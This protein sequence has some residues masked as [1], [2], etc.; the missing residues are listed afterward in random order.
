MLP[1]HPADL[2]LFFDLGKVLVAFDHQVMVENLAR[3][4]GVAGESVRA[5]LFD[6][7]LEDAYERGEITSETFAARL[8]AIGRHPVDQDEL[9]DAAGAMFSVQRDMVPVLQ[10]CRQAGVGMG[11]L[12]NTCEA[13]WEWL[14]RHPMETVVGWFD[15]VVLSYRVHAMKP[16][17]SI[18]RSAERMA[19]VG[20][21]SIFFID[22]RAENVEGARAAGWRATLF[23]DAP[24][25]NRQLDAFLPPLIAGSALRESRPGH[26]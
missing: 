6:Q 24:N 19:G 23:V 13:H 8:Q 25:L 26:R 9:L 1:S 5:L 17:L 18:Y 10:R 15:P 22:D 21:E 7:G 11:L 12:S 16:D 20:P 14:Q 2:F 4:L 3:L